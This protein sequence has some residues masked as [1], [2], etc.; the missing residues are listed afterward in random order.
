MIDL[1]PC[2]ACSRHV[3]VDAQACPFCGSAIAALAPRAVPRGRLTRAAVFVAGT[4]LAGASGC[5]GSESAEDGQ[6]YD[7]TGGGDTGGGSSGGG[8]DSYNDDDDADHDVAMPYGAPPA[9]SRLV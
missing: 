6:D 5:G 8:G 4:A 3:R 9:R 7:T 2:S 1:T